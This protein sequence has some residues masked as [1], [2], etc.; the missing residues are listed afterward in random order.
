MRALGIVG[1]LALAIAALVG[2]LVLGAG[3]AV[4]GFVGSDDTVFNEPAA[5]GEDGRPI[6][7][8]PDLLAYDDITVTLRASAPDGVFIGT[9]HPVDVADFVGDSSRIRLTSVTRT[10]VEAEDVGTGSPVQPASADFWTRSMSGDGVE[11][12]TLDRDNS[13]AQWVIAPRSGAGPTTVSFG[14]TV[15]G[16]HRAALIAAA[17]GALLLVVC[18]ELLL[19]ARRLRRTRPPSA[20]ERIAA[21]VPPVPPPSS[22]GKR[23]AL[24]VAL[25]L[26]LTGCDYQDHLPAQRQS[27]DLATT[28][29]ALT[30]AELPALFES[31]DARVRAAI[32]ASRPPRYSTSKW[33]AA[34]RGPAL[35]SDL[36][37][38]RVTQLTSLGRRSAPT[39]KG[40]EAFTGRFDSY[41]MWSLV[42][43]KSGRE[44]RLD[45]FTKA[46]VEAVWLR[47]AGSA[48][49]G[50]LPAP[51]QPGPLPGGD[52]AATATSA[53]RDY[54]RTGE[55][56][57]RLELDAT[58]KEWRDNIADLGGRAMF[59]GFTVEAEPELTRV[60][61]VA[62]GALALVA[63]RVTTRLDGRPD[64]AV[65]WA[66]PYGKYRPVKGSRL[67]FA[68]IAVGVIHLPEKGTPTMLG[69]TFSEVEVKG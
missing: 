31:Y 41:P 7:T 23:V 14:V 28:K 53:W 62:D 4:A 8:A 29:V 11:E 46:S 9:A 18:V 44:T 67:S 6:L 56:D 2:L 61:S 5:L 25:V 3:A 50:D 63:V 42:A 21:Y 24:S 58:S 65:R 43:S 66:A 68:D 54:L 34:D 69:S 15:E 57:D 16:I 36:F 12:L 26:V 35:E 10:G 32:K 20:A 52:A 47:H 64:L 27:A 19:R 13:A 17:A 39:H 38:T 30:P 37:G 48:V 33:D 51:G 49:A 55:R 45:L 1:R 60:V 22:R 59:R 40:I